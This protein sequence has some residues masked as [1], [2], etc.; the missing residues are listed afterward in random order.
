MQPGLPPPV[1]ASGPV[2]F[3]EPASLTNTL[4]LT[5]AGLPWGLRGWHP[6]GGFLGSGRPL[7]ASC[8]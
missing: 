7:T 4:L 1:P 2:P 3:T 6:A 8:W 5:H